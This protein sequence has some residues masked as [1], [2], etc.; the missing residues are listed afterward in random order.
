MTIRV[1][2]AVSTTGIPA[3][4]TANQNFDDTVASANPDGGD[5]G[6]VAVILADVLALTSEVALRLLVEVDTLADAAK[7]AVGDMHQ[8]ESFAKSRVTELEKGL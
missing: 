8:M 7:A 3:L 2:A 4:K 5:L 6:D 1:D